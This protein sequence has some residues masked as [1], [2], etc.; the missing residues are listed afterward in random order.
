MA[1]KVTKTKKKE[2]KNIP[3]GNAYISATFNN[4]II[5]I[6]DTKGNVIAWGSS[7]TAGFKGSRKGTPFA[8]QL[9]AEAVAKKAKEHGLKKV[10]VFTKGPGS[11]R[12]TAVKSLQVN[13]IEIGVIK[14]Q[15]PVPHNGPRQKKRRRV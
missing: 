3:N 12:D 11:G 7:G 13:G 10:D 8:A 5:S 4:T 9:A 6:A 1:K 15:T 14:D 2:K